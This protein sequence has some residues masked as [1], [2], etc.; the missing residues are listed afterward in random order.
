[1]KRTLLSKIMLLLCAL[2]AGSGS[3][4]ADDQTITLTYKS[5]GLETS[6]KEKTDTVSGF[7]FTVD[8]GYKGS[9][10]VIQMN[11]SKG[12]GILYNTTAIPGLKSIKVNV[13]SG[14]KTYTITTG[15]SVKPTANSQTGTTGG[16]Y[17]ASSGD[18]YFQLKVSGASYFSSI[19]ITYT[20]SAGSSD[21]SITADDVNIT[22]NA[23]SG[24]IAYSVKNGGGNVTAN[25]TSG[26]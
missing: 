2:A 3:M 8:Q 4:W 5:F 10:N 14:N 7:E 22:S 19:E 12:S 25:V 26:D 9:G 17:N 16:T 23:T 21:P 24:S 6:Y 20:P 15:T 13:S 11:P 18:T 1:M